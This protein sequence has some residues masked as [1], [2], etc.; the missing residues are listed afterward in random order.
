MTLIKRCLPLTSWWRRG[1]LRNIIVDTVFSGFPRHVSNRISA[2]HPRTP[3][4][5]NRGNAIRDTS[6][7]E[8]TYPRP[9]RPPPRNLLSA[10]LHP[11]PRRRRS[12]IDA[13]APRDDHVA[14]SLIYIRAGATHV[15]ATRRRAKRKDSP[16]FFSLPSTRRVT[17][18][19]D[20]P[21]ALIFDA[22]RILMLHPGR[23]HRDIRTLANTTRAFTYLTELAPTYPEF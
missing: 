17:A 15:Y 3:L 4:S 5:S 6:G 19:L 14:R 11:R 9:S 16:P 7:F 22:A 21:R 20:A 2:H 12:H 8:G 1:W 13:P 18:V 10:C 23:A